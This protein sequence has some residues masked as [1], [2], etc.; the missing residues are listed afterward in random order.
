MKQKKVQSLSRKLF[1]NFILSCLLPIVAVSFL[2]AYLFGRYQY[3]EIRSRAENNTKLISAYMTKYI[4][5]IDNLTKAPY[6]HS[7]FQSKTSFEDLSPYDQNKVGE[8]IGKLLQ[9][10]TYSRED[11]GDM[12]VMSDGNVLYFNASDWYQYLPTINPLTGRNWYQAAMKKNGRVA[13]VPGKDRS[14][15]EEEGTD[16]GDEPLDTESF[17]ISRKLNN[18]FLQ[19]QENVIML[20]LKT[21]DFENL[22]SSLTSNAPLIIAFTN[23]EGQLIYSN[24]PLTRIQTASLQQQKVDY[25]HRSWLCFSQTLEHYPLTVHVLLSASYIIDRIAIFLFMAGACC[26]LC[27]ILGYVMFKKNNYWIERPTY[28]IKAVLGELKVGNLNSRCEPLVIREFNEIGT[29]INAMAAQLQETI[30][31][32]YELKLAQKN[33]QLQALQSQIQPH[34]IINTIYSF[35]T[36]NQIGE[37][38]T[39]NDAFYSFAHLLRYVLSRSRETTLG[40]ELDFLNDYCSLCLLRFGNRLSYEI[41]CPEE[42]RSLSMPK[43]LLQPLVENAVIHGIEP[44]EVPCKLSVEA[45]RHGNSLYIL[46]ED[47][48]VGFKDE[49]LNSPD[50]IGIKNVENRISL[51]GAGIKLYIYRIEGRT[52]QVLIVPFKEEKHE[53]TGDR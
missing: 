3:Q 29:S 7:F 28:H 40:A 10:T 50:S 22:F 53:D 8:E 2:V 36:L 35:I 52:I 33:L 23:E 18:M 14:K 31:N 4:N 51:W 15:M 13:I 48:G 19:D 9:L 37:Q 45:E 47:N 20:N 11:F 43:L 30:R 25:D 27:S 26:L 44:S 24:K 12:L 6:Y 16:T 34:F 41:S 17:Y 49:E 38:E 21:D 42:L 5:D 46:I 32:E 39:L 1:V